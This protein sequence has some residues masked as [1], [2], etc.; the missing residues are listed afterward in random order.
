[1]ACPAQIITKKKWKSKNQLS[2]YVCN[3]YKNPEAF[4]LYNTAVS[5]A[6]WQGQID[7]NALIAAFDAAFACPNEGHWPL[8]IFQCPLV[9]ELE[10]CQGLHFGSCV[11]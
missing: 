2:S 10:A 11:D 7:R 4:V 5:F 1:M 6:H 8:S 9:K 3:I